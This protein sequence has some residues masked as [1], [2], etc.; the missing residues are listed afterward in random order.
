VPK[1]SLLLIVCFWVFL[2][3]TACGG[4]SV[5]EGGPTTGTANVTDTVPNT[6]NIIDQTDVAL[7]TS[8]QSIAFTVTGINAATTISVTDGEYS[9]D[10][11]PYAS[12]PGTVINDQAIRVRHISS[13]N[14]STVIS[15]VVTIGG[16]SG[17]F[18]STTTSMNANYS[19]VDSSEPYA[20]KTTSGILF[21]TAEINTITPQSFD[22][23]LDLYEPDVDLSGHSLPMM[24]IIHGGGFNSGSRTQNQ[25]VAFAQA[26]ARQ[27]YLAASIDYR[28]RPQDPVL[29][30]EMQA[31]ENA[32]S[33]VGNKI[34]MLAAAEDT[35][36]AIRWMIE[37]AAKFHIDTDRIG[38]LG[39]SAGAATAL[40]VGYA[41]D[42]FGFD[43]PAFKVVV[44]LWG[45]LG[46]GYD[47]PSVIS[48]A[49]ISSTE[50]PMIVIHGEN[51]MTVSYDHSVRLNTIAT[52]NG[53]PIEFIT[54]VGAGHGFAANGIFSLERFPI[55][56]IT[57]FR[58]IL[59][60]VNVAT[61]LPDCLRLELTIDNCQI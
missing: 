13:I 59:D 48:P 2:I 55:N 29:S 42:G 20:V 43:L 31:L 9:I 25:L 14:P 22:L 24:I 18:S 21:G 54:N 49:T 56:G 15:T 32:V 60:F 52:T 7:G 51:D 26:F 45:S 57:Q 41:L 19:G 27:G 38:L 39:A 50:A 16:V 28:L 30:A 35:V 12:D 10:G 53:L 8:I 11:G 36:S 61:L 58:R 34:A 6:F 1:R 40:N 23:L 17:T 46:I 4:G 47:T 44:N 5:S 33:H 37:N 3:L